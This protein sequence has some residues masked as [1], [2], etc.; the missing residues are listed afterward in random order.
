[1]ES[2]RLKLELIGQIVNL[3]RLEHSCTFGGCN[4]EYCHTVCRQ[5]QTAAQRAEL[6]R[7]KAC[8]MSAPSDGLHAPVHVS[9][10]QRREVQVYRCW[11]V[12]YSRAETWIQPLMEELQQIYCSP[13]SPGASQTFTFLLQNG[14]M[15][16]LDLYYWK[17]RL[18]RDFCFDPKQWRIV[19]ISLEWGFALEQH[20]DPER[21]RCIKLSRTWAAGPL[22]PS[23]RH[24]GAF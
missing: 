11:L 2:E 19:N 20:K 4:A 8:I 24:R 6:C 18:N 1:M 5:T 16:K 12:E 23:C 7:H 15:S 9:G 13:L 22:K 21:Q 10:K 3:V 14:L 17:N